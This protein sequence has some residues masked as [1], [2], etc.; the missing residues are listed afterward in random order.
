MPENMNYIGLQMKIAIVMR[1]GLNPGLLANAAACIASG[2]F[3]REKDLLGEEIRGHDSMSGCIFIPITKIPILIKKQTKPFLEILKRA[4]NRKLKFMV[5][6]KEAQ[7]TSDY[8]EYVQRVKGKKLSEIEVLG[9]GAIGEDS[10]IDQFSGDL[11]L[12]K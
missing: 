1:E 2:L 7:S 8:N 10:L 3:N 12:L 11:P 5:F 6:T 9:I 4:K